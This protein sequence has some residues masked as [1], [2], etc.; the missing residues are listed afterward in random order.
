LIDELGDVTETDA[1][2]SVEETVDEVLN[3]VVEVAVESPMTPEPV[4]TVVVTQP[5]EIDVATVISRDEP[6]ES[7]QEPS[8]EEATSPRRGRLRL[9]VYS[10]LVF[11][12]IVG[13]LLY[14]LAFRKDQLPPSS[15]NGSTTQNQTFPTVGDISEDQEDSSWVKEYLGIKWIDENSVGKK[16]VAAQGGYLLMIR[17]ATKDH[18][19]FDLYYYADGSAAF[20]ENITAGTVGDSLSFSFDDDGFGHS[21]NGNLHFRDGAIDVDVIV[22][23]NEPLPE[24]VHSLAMNEV[25]VPQVLPL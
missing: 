11:L 17:E 25:L 21:G 4:N 24:N 9:V 18:V 20:A 1:S 12:V 2:E 13:V 14:L 3:Q 5:D 8:D 6:Q 7:C 19:T 16:D 15:E 23:D 22:N 10:V